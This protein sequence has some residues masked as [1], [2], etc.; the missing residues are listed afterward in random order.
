MVSQQD[1]FLMLFLW[2]LTLNCDIAFAA[3][4][5]GNTVLSQGEIHTKEC[6][7]NWTRQKAVI[8]VC[9]DEFTYHQQ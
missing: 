3:H 7:L 2:G 5:L 4:V 9:N 8:V 6:C 1:V